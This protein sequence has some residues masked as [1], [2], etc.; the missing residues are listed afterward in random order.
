MGSGDRLEVQTKI[1][2][3]GEDAF[4]AVLE[5]QLPRGVS[6]INANTSEPGLSILCSPPT[7]LNNYTLHC[8]VGQLMLLLLIM[9]YRALQCSILYNML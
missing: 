8:E 9:L 1:I 6:Y 4:G 2:N 3:T 5:V 7:P